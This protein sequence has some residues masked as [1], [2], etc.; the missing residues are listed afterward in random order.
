VG[1]RFAAAMEGVWVASLRYLRSTLP[2][3]RGG[4]RVRMGPGRVR[5][6]TGEWGVRKGGARTK[7]TSAAV[8]GVIADEAALAFKASVDRRLRKLTREIE[9]WLSDR[10]LGKKQTVGAAAGKCSRCRRFAEDGWKFCPY[11][12]GE[13]R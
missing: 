12:G 11:D 2:G 4:E 8:G 3:E 1:E 9:V 13:V 10:A 6:R 5:G 7:G